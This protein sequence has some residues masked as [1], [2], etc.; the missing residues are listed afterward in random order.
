MPSAWTARWGSGSPAIALGSDVDGIPQSNQKPGVGYRE[1]IMRT[2]RPLMEPYYY[3]PTRFDTYL[4]QL[5]IEYPTV[6]ETPDRSV[7]TVF[8]VQLSTRRSGQCRS[9]HT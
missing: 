3:D 7:T 9:V 2:Y 5:G 1:Q 8:D 4:E 6:R